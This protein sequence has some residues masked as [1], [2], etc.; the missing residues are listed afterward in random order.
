MILRRS[1]DDDDD[2][3]DDGK[4]EVKRLQIFNL[5]CSSLIAAV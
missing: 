2:D 1:D 4:V 3:D 5:I